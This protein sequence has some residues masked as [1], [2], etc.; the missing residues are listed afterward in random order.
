M[1]GERDV[2][3]AVAAANAAFALNSPWR[4]MSNLDRRNLLW[5]FADLLDR[6]REHLAYLTRITLGAPYLAFGTG[7][8]DTAIENFRC[9]NIACSFP[10]IKIFT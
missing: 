9:K 6:D 5:R 8:I 2:D 7:E 4:T 1:A 10:Y 3:I